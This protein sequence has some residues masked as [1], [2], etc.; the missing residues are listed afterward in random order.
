MSSFLHNLA[1]RGAG[2]AVN[3]IQAPTP[4]P[5]RPNAGTPELAPIEVAAEAR[6]EGPDKAPPESGSILERARET[7]PRPAVQRFAAQTEYRPPSAPPGLASSAPSKQVPS[8]EQVPPAET[9]AVA[10]TRVLRSVQRQEAAAAAVPA[11]VPTP[12]PHARQAGEAAAAV[13]KAPRRRAPSLVASARAAAAP[14]P[15]QPNVVIESRTPSS[16][17]AAEQSPTPSAARPA[18]PVIRPASAEDTRAL[19]AP[20][21][22]PKVPPVP[23]PSP[24]TA[25]PIHVRIGRVEVRGTPP[26][27]PPAVASAIAP[28]GFAAYSRIRRYRN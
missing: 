7:L 11:A 1:R 22:L 4:S 10:Q 28:A 21:R 23:S 24:P 6:P 12:P 18:S 14:V 3:S 16:V 15:G 13:R 20:L 17:P 8:R 5:I 9:P 27:P 2:L 25:L 26:Q 19:P